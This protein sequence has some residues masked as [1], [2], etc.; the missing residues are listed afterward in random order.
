[1]AF[2]QIAAFARL[3]NGDAAPV[4]RVAGQATLISR[5]DHDLEYDSV[6]D[7]LIVGNPEGGAILVF[8][9][10]ASGEEPPVRVI[11]GP[12]TQ[13]NDPGYGTFVDPVHNELYV[14]EKEYILVFSRTAK[15]DVPPLRVI[16]GPDTMLKN[17][18][19]IQVDPGRNIIFAATNNGMLLFNRTDN[20][21]VKPRAAIKGPMS[22]I[23]TTIQN[24]R[25]SPKGYLVASL[26][27]GRG[28]DEGGNAA[29][30]EQGRGGGARG[31][32]RGIVAWSMDEMA[33]AQG[34]ADIAP[35]FILTNPKGRTEGQRIALNPKA[36]EV[37]LGGERAVEV[38]SYPEIF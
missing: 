24:F 32:I 8:R 22:G 4:R 3:A 16:K 9:G 17:A 27:G 34:P 7:E 10:S 14:C 26:S 1:V 38:Y 36:K 5:A 15:G 30:A 35:A 12:H 21:N 31:G 20:G 11:Q 19:G 2:P 29:A 25:L 6:N 28:G 23:R 13:I 37:M 18:R 33:A